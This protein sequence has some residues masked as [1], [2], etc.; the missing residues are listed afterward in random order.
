MLSG[1]NGILQKATDAKT[2]TERASVIEQARTDVLGYQAEN[3]GGYLEKA[4]LKSVLDT[5]FKDVPAVE[6]LPDG[7]ELMNLPLTTLD[8][9]GINT[10]KV[11]E[12]YNG[13]INNSSNTELKI[14]DYVKYGD[15]LTVTTYTTDTN[16]TGYTTVQ[17]FT[18]NKN[19]LWRVLSIKNDKIELV[20]TQNILADDNPLGLYLKDKN[21]FLNAEKILKDLCERLY[22][23]DYG[24]A[25]SINVE[26]INQL[27]EYTPE[28]IQTYTYTSG[29]PYWDKS[30]NTFKEK[31]SSVNIAND[32]YS[33]TINTNIPLYDT[34]VT[35]IPY[36]LSSRCTRADGF[37]MDCDVRTVNNGEVSW[38]RIYY[39]NMMGMSSVEN[40][41]YAVRPI[42][43]L[44]ASTSIT[45]GIGTEQNPFEL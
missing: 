25:R 31:N 28:D 20:A 14:G 33:Y 21:G 41:M 32:Y 45:K 24:T 40:G 36:W 2:F 29:G 34:L 23:S 13:K 30:T 11:S 44:N 4:Q 12:I 17:T 27:T 39:D 18:T 3:K 43:T 5:Y 8:K 38:C 35:E 42:V 1:D 15:K 37:N 10:I 7:D 26:D 16:E 22:N 6:E 19:M 9:Y